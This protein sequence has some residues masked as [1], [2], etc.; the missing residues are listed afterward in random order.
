VR[1]GPAFITH[2][3]KKGETLAEIAKK[4]GTTVR[5]IRRAN[6]LRST[7]IQAKKT[8]KIPQAGHAP[9]SFSAGPIGI[10]PRR[11]PPKGA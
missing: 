6:G 10:P 1:P 2:V 3:A 4:Y 5:A 8:Y 9:P 11:L 7:V